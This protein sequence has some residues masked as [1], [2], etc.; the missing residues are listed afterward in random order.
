MRQA[1]QYL[2]MS[3][4]KQ[5][6][7]I[8]AQEAA[9]AEYAS[10]NEIF[11]IATYI[12]EARS[13]LSLSGREGM[14]RLLVDVAQ[15]N[16]PFDAI[17][18]LDVTRWG[19]FQDVDESAYYEYHCRRWGVDVFY[20][21]E[22]FRSAHPLDSLMKQLKRAMAAEYSRELGVK[23]RAGVVRAV[24]SGYAAGSLPCLGYRRQA[25]AANGEEKGLL[26]SRERK[27]S[28]TDRVRWVLGPPN[29]VARVQKIFADY[30][31][32]KPIVN[33]CGELA[34]EG[35]NSHGGKAITHFMLYAL[36][37]NPIV[38]GVFEWGARGRQKKAASATGIERMT[39]NLRNSAMLSPIVP[40][41]IWNR[42]QVKMKAA[43]E[44]RERG[45]PDEILIRKL[46]D[47]L[48]AHS[49]LRCKDFRR[50]GLAST[51]AY[52]RH[53]GSVE[54]AYHLA[55]VEDDIEKRL[56]FAQALSTG[57][58]LRNR[59]IRD[60]LSLLAAA[61]VQ[62]HRMH[63]EGFIVINDVQVVVKAAR[64]LKS[65]KAERWE[66]PQ[67]RRCKA[68]GRWLLVMRLNAN[69]V[70]GRDFYLLPPHE[71]QQ[72]NGLMN[73]AALARMARFQLCTAPAV[74]HA[75]SELGAQKQLV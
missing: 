22:S 64:M 39:E 29:E 60:L 48:R 6:F 26:K 1:A 2:R 27:P 38:V 57:M 13:G 49:D 42:A 14:R 43:R 56:T 30:V 61:G 28:V 8:A 21:A 3:S 33:I 74:A 7:S 63:P 62:A 32:G 54:H 5:P 19:R 73:T 65:V 51:D 10:R 59:L 52:R 44:H 16:C 71:M 40:K 53:F 31:N 23:C 34:S 11:I 41:E 12:D 15:V 69:E 25:I 18:V 50:Y 72:F 75:L 45:I 47:A 70:T 68:P 4:D 35:I 9:I 36:F 46:H 17:L 37:R 24:T 58:N 55:G 67:L 66:T 20:V